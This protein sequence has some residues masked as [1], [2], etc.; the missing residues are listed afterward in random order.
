[1]VFY[2]KPSNFLIS[3]FCSLYVPYQICQI[4]YFICYILNQVCI[5]IMHFIIHEVCKGKQHSI[6]M[7]PPFLI[8]LGATLGLCSSAVQWIIQFSGS[9]SSVVYTAQWSV[10]RAVQWFIQ[11]SGSCSSVVCTV[12]WFVQFSGSCNLVIHA[13]QWFMQ[14]S[15]SCSSVVCTVQWFVQFSGSAVQWYICA[16]QW[17]VQFIV[18]YSSVVHAV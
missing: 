8:I 2:E 12:Q 14:S 4:L 6:D 17:F 13:V 3:Y 1:M 16:V 10:V 5:I 15:G 9:C 18:S 11:F 7:L